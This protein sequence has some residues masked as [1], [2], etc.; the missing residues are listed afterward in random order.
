MVR[1][2]AE[3]I[4]KSF[5]LEEI[6][7]LAKTKAQRD[8]SDHLNDFKKH[9]DSFTP[10]YAAKIAP[11]ATTRGPKKGQLK[12][13]RKPGGKKSLGDYLLESIG[14]SPM[15]IDEIMR[16]IESRGYRSKSKDPR[17]VLYLELKKQVE[18]GGIDKTG[19]GMYKIR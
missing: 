12:R 17:R 15:T 18:N 4:L 11:P 19:R 7:D 14:N 10:G 3:T 9:L 13:G 1:P 5:T 2:S 8:V 6:L 16:A